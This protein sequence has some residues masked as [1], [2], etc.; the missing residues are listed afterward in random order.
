MLVLFVALAATIQSPDSSIHASEEILVTARR[1]GIPVWRARRGGSTLILVG[2]ITDIAKGTPWN[3]HALAATIGRSD[4]VMYPQSVGL[5]AS[6]FQMIGWLSKWK[7][8]SK[9]PKAQ[10]LSAMLNAT[11]RSRLARLSAQG[12]APRNWDR[13]H[14]LHLAFEMRDIVSKRTGIAPRAATV[15]DQATRKHKVKRVPIARAR[16]SPLARELFVSKPRDHLGCLV[17]TLAM[18]E[19]GPGELRRRS[20]AWANRQV[21]S[22]L[23]SLVETVEAQCWPANSEFRLSGDLAATANQVLDSTGTT[24][25]VLDL[26]SLADRG[27]LLDRLKA[28]GVRIDGPDWR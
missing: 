3:S 27:G 28:A 17:A 12:L 20:H 6:P 1:T 8:Q 10:S 18:S 15:V 13:M 11:D 7:K 14:P 26:G 25:A 24:L 22:V 23:H 2:T 16:A 5:T 19:A 21:S 4:R 9:L